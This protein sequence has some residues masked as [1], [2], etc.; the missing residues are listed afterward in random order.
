MDIKPP[1]HRHPTV[2]A[3]T[4]CMTYGCVINW[5]PICEVPDRLEERMKR[6]IIVMAVLAGVLGVAQWTG[7]S[8]VRPA[9][10]GPCERN[11]NAC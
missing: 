8:I 5:Y 11:P 9:E 1:D 2:V 6:A 3:F 4:S 10:A 7:D